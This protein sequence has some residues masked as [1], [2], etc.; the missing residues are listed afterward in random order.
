MLTQDTRCGSLLPPAKSAAWERRSGL[1]PVE[2]VLAIPLILF[3]VALSVI[4][5][6]AACWKIRAS[7]VARNEI[8]SNRRPRSDTPADPRPAGWPQSATMNHSASR[9]LSDLNVPAFQNPLI[10]GPM[11]NVTVNSRLFDPTQ[12]VRL[13]RSN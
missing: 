9:P 7:I 11:P 4:I 8:W 12:A 2:L 6:N 13:G 3:T 10:R 5:G 1:A